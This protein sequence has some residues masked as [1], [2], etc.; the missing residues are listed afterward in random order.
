[1]NTNQM[2][3]DAKDV[4]PER[5]LKGSRGGQMS[6]GNLQRLLFMLES[7]GLGKM[8]HPSAKGRQQRDI[9][10][11]QYK[12]PVLSELALSNRPGSGPYG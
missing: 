8:G 4:Y 10:H 9:L 11:L 3:L 2:V 5:F 1:M 6:P 12:K 7:A